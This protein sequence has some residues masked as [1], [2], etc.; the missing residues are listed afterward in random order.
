MVSLGLRK[1]RAVALAA[2]RWCMGAGGLPPGWQWKE[3][4]EGKRFFVHPSGAITWSDPRRTLEGYT[5][6]WVAAAERGD[7]IF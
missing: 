1:E 7:P 3:D 5:Q 4:G 6:E 2:A